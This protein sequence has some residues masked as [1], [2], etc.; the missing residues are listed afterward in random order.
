[1]AGELERKPTWMTVVALALSRADGRW[2]MHRRPP[3]KHHG[4]L[5][6]FP[7]GKVEPGEDPRLALV[8]EVNE[9]L[10]LALDAAALRPAAF[11][12]CAAD[13]RQPAIVI[14]LYT[15]PLPPAEP[16]A[17]EGGELGWFSPEDV[18]A[19]PMPPLDVALAERPFAGPDKGIAKPG[20]PAYV[21]PSK[22]A[23]SSAG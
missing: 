22:R 12:D 5:W 11:A 15:S 19:L 7:G 1:M 18:R 20:A 8:R 21:P 9:E 23:R 14:L 16:R 4:G 6:E 13:L 3:H 10:G 17:L 2:L